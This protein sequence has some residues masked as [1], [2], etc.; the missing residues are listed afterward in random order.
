MNRAPHQRTLGHLDDLPV[1]DLLRQE[2]F[3]KRNGLWVPARETDLVLQ[4]TTLWNASSARHGFL[5]KLSGTATE[6]M[7]GDGN[8][9]TPAGHLE[10][11]EN[12]EFASHATSYTFSGLDGD[13]DQM[14]VFFY[15]MVKDASG[16]QTTYFRPNGTTTNQRSRWYYTGSGGFVSNNTDTAG[17]LVLSP[18]GGSANETDAGFGMIHC[19]KDFLRSA[20]WFY[21]E[22]N[23]TDLFVVSAGWRWNETSTN[24]TSFD[25]LSTATNGIGAGSYLR[26]YRVRRTA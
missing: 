3:A 20:R 25:L 4:D 13:T 21:N 8:W 5:K 18:N 22:S 1:S 17:G 7:G 12:K 2:S 19:K 15:R 24:I 10:L 16:A 11:I 23:T 6:Y 14:W 9:S 26:L